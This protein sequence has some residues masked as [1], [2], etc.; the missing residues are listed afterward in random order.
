[1][2]TYH[3]MAAQNPVISPPGLSLPIGDPAVIKANM[4]QCAARTTTLKQSMLAV[5]TSATRLGYRPPSGPADEN[6][7]DRFVGH[8]E[9]V[10]ANIVATTEDI[11]QMELEIKALLAKEQST[12]SGLAE[13][14]NTL[15]LGDA[16]Q[17]DVSGITGQLPDPVLKLMMRTVVN[18][19]GDAN[20]YRLFDPEMRSL[21]LTDEAELEQNVVCSQALDLGTDPQ[22]SSLQDDLD[23]A[24]VRRQMA[25]AV[26]AVEKQAANNAVEKLEALRKTAAEE[27]AAAK[28]MLD[29][30]L[31]END[32]QREKL[33][34][35]EALVVSHQRC[36]ADL[37]EELC[38][39]EANSG[40]TVLQLEDTIRQNHVTISS[41][42]ESNTTLRRDLDDSPVESLQAEL[43]RQQDAVDTLQKQLAD[44]T[45]ATARLGAELKQD[46]KKIAVF[47]DLVATN[48][49]LIASLE[50]DVGVAKDG[51]QQEGV[52]RRAADAEVQSA[53]D[54][55]IKSQARVLHMSAQYTKA[56]TASK[57]LRQDLSNANLQL[58]HDEVQLFAEKANSG[59]L[60][61]DLDRERGLR[62]AA[63]RGVA[64]LTLELE[65]SR[66]NSAD[67][68]QAAE[69]HL[70]EEAQTWRSVEAE[71]RA[72]RSK[73]EGLREAA[74]KQAA[75]LESRAALLR[76]KLQSAAHDRQTAEER[77]AEQQKA[78]ASTEIGLHGQI[79]RLQ[80]TVGEQ[81][82]DTVG[83]G[84]LTDAAEKQLQADRA[85]WSAEAE[86]LSGDRERLVKDVSALQARI[87]DVEHDSATW[88]EKYT[89]LQA[90]ATSVK[91][92]FEWNRANWDHIR[93]ELVDQIAKLKDDVNAGVAVNDSGRD[94]LH[95]LER[96]RR[97]TL[98]SAGSLCEGIFSHAD[99]DMDW[100][101]VC[102]DLGEADVLCASQPASPYWTV[103]A[104]PTSVRPDDSP[105]PDRLRILSEMDVA[106]D[107]IAFALRMA[108]DGTTP[109][110]V[111]P[112]VNALARSLATTQHASG[113][114]LVGLLRTIIVR[115][116]AEEAEERGVLLAGIHA[117][118]FLSRR[119]GLDDA[120]ELQHQLEQ[121]LNASSAL[122]TEFTPIVRDMDGQESDAFVE[123]RREE[124]RV[125]PGTVV[126]VNGRTHVA[127]LDFE[128]RAVTILPVCRMKKQ[129]PYGCLSFQSPQSAVEPSV[130]LRGTA[131]NAK[132]WMEK[133]L[134]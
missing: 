14:I 86:R 60:R 37:R 16:P 108:V 18:R 25:L 3:T 95:R 116:G 98:H 72:D 15:N 2:N 38:A 62:E 69:T 82:E 4:E 59:G 100:F 76:G 112:L 11:E 88:Q 67:R 118:H 35:L 94:N 78:W 79:T 8:S 57:K 130:V 52:A 19:Q 33:G 70:A 61:Q 106:P 120:V 102:C 29:G 43:S 63:E 117:L 129:S 131:R 41:L 123:A 48:T 92:D 9:Q 26:I 97:A 115:Q 77:S 55:L 34:E 28:E 27:K 24:N 83:L 53:K 107:G 54:S 46:G 32:L 58:A 17:T 113:V 99:A 90:T 49:R 81:E 105:D 87:R 1:M 91:G 51:L 5:W 119:F 132:W 126:V 30:A 85:A 22:L 66:A 124:G 80:E 93:N 71:L 13:R 127:L 56:S 36:V 109:W 40:K 101:H 89:Q 110:R 6:E 128:K 20:F 45:A 114:L 12:E 42:E 68:L 75:L 134:V 84:A 111:L 121:K 74:E 64:A 21:V 125:F 23:R 31:G 10:N 44:Q 39:K 7:V 133:T 96:R 103:G 73:E 65:S 104:W 122:L 47:E 50:R